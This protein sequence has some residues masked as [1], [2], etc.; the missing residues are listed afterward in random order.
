VVFNCKQE[1]EDPEIQAE[2]KRKDSFTVIHDNGEEESF[3]LLS[4]LHGI[5]IL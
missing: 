2:I 4:P 5:R 3:S 1:H